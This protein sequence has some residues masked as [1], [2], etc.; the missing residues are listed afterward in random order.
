M[1]AA[2]PNSIDLTCK[3]L[4]FAFLLGTATVPIAG[5]EGARA[6][7]SVTETIK[8]TVLSFEMVPVPEGTVTVNGLQQQVAPFLIGRTE[9]TWDLYDAYRMDD[10]SPAGA[11]ATTRPS[12]PYGAPDYNWG[13]NG[14]P[15]ISVTRN[16]AEQF[17]KWLSA[18]T[19][20]TYR[21]PTEAEWVRAAE[22]AAG[23][24]S[25]PAGREAM[26]WHSGNAKGTTHPVGKRTADA[27]GLFDLFGNAAEW[28]MST[29]DQPVTR[30]GSFRDPVEA[31]GPAARDPYDV[32]WQE[33]DP[34]LPKSRWW[35][36]DG[37]F[38]GFRVVTTAK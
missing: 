33:R 19:G 14:Y 23:P 8:G 24:G 7:Q 22:L 9:V 36:S 26:T 11:D 4:A 10:S 28:V 27:L 20:K 35:L 16:A 25:T 31:T 12:Q 38:V 15:V 37:P 34:Q 29:D 21:L 30:G 18:K 2:L 3:A 13:H 6:G 17:C 5:G 32:A 1:V